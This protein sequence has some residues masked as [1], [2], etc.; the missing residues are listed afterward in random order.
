VCMIKKNRN[1]KLL[2]KLKFVRADAICK[3]FNVRQFRY[4]KKYGFYMRGV[5]AILIDVGLVKLL[6]VKNGYRASISKT[7]FIITD[8]IELNAPH[9]LSLYLRH[10][11]I[12]VFFRNTKQLLSLEKFLCRS[13]YTINGHISLIFIAYIFLEVVK[14]SKHLPTIGKSQEFLSNLVAI[15]MKDTIYYIYNSQ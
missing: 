12:E 11:D 8:M 5:E 1:L 2:D 10:W 4:Y 3:S 6:M 9:I 13:P 14:D 15:T 7:R